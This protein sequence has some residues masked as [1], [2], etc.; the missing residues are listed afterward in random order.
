MEKVINFPTTYKGDPER[1]NAIKTAIAYA[2]DRL[3]AL[4]DREGVHGLR[5]RL[6]GVYQIDLP[7]AVNS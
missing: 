2:T 5:R 4:G 3:I 1:N 6:L 7:K